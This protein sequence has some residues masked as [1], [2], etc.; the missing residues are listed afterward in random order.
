MRTGRFNVKCQFYKMI[1][2][3]IFKVK[4]IQY[5]LEA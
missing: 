4:Q 3:L 2:D 1:D 5:C